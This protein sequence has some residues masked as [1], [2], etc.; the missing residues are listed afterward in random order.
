MSTLYNVLLLLHFIGLAMLVGGFFAQMGAT[1]RT[2]THWMRDG[3]LT[4]LITGFAMVGIV[5]SG[6]LEDPSELNNTAV[7]IKL[8]IALVVTVL[9]LVGM[10]QDPEKQ[11]PYWAACGALALVNMVVAVFFL[12]G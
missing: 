7:A 1:P 4:Q 11:Q 5:Q 2:V 9:A 3:V 8:G 10:R 6:S 12:G